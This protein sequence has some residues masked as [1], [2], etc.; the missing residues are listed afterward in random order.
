MSTV[1]LPA[2]KDV[3]DMLAGLVGRNVTVS[4]GAPV[5]P[6]ADKPVSVAVYVAPDMSINALCVM[7]LAASRRRG[8]PHLVKVGRIVK[9]EP[10]LR[11]EHFRIV[12]RRWMPMRVVAPD[13]QLAAVVEQ[14]AHRSSSRRRVGC[15][16]RAI[17]VSEVLDRP[18]AH[19]PNSRPACH[20]SAAE[21]RAARADLGAQRVEIPD[22]QPRRERRI[23][24]GHVGREVECAA[25]GIVPVQRPL[26]AA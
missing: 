4:P 20:D 22:N 8:C 13:E 16:Q 26:R 14:H 15:A 1:T 24:G 7:D 17:G 25:H 21:Q 11:N 18:V 10:G 2:P 5:T 3:R 12:H 6:T 19:L 9:R 23:A